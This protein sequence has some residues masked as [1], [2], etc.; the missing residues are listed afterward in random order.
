MP[1]AIMADTCCFRRKKPDTFE[2]CFAFK[3]S[4]Q[5]SNPFTQ[6]VRLCIY[7]FTEEIPSYFCRTEF[8]SKLIFKTSYL[9]VSYKTE[10]A[11]GTWYNC[12][13]FVYFSARD[14]YVMQILNT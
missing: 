11:I 5:N 10:Y 8:C 6:N 1:I 14:R 13:F 3:Y 4:K 9:L 7:D 2:L 12:S